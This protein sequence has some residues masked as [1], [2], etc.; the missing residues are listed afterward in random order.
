MNSVKER[1]RER[2][3]G[4]EVSQLDISTL[5][6]PDRIAFFRTHLTVRKSHP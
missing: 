2:R 4:L 1:E 3:S 6:L 5:I